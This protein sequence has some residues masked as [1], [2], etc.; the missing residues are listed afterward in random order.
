MS[1]ARVTGVMYLGLAIAGVMWVAVTHPAIYD[2]HNATGT[3]ANIGAHETRAYLDV[4]A[5][6]VIVLTQ[7][8]GWET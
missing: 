7:A 2:S 6:L 1:T 5:E 8:A 4:A 3:L